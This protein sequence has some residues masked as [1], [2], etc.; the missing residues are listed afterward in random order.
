M[1]RRN[2]A[3]IPKSIL[4]HLDF[5]LKRLAAVQRQRHDAAEGFKGVVISVLVAFKHTVALQDK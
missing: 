5:S 2:P 1:C 4:N 3:L